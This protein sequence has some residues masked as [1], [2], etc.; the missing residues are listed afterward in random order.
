M[1]NFSA[2]YSAIEICPPPPIIKIC[3][4]P[5]NSTSRFQPLDQGIIQ[6]FKAYYKRQWL[7][8]TLESYESNIDPYLTRNIRLAIWWILRSWKNE[9]TNTTI[10]N[11]FRKSTLILAPI[12]LPTPIL[13]PGISELYTQVIQAGKIEDAIT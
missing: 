5:A 12:S 1:D 2:H 9:V 4:L 6:N 7:Q 10:C 8:F 11:C 13:P 3:W